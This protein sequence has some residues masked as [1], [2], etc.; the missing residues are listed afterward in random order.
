MSWP[1]PSDLESLVARFHART[2]PKSEWTHLAHLAVGTWQVHAEGPERALATLR[3][4]IQL[5]N[6]A[7]GTANTDTGGYHET[8][9][10]AY[11]VLIAESLRQPARQADLA[12][13]VQELLA[14]PLAPREAL[15]AFYSKA[16]LF[17]VEARRGWVEP[18]R[19]PLTLER[20]LGDTAHVAQG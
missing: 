15:L 6:E 14:S 13:S 11:V 17:S 9:T 1:S 2:L 19:A 12:A 5:L 18:D 8:I 20:L 4:G 10:T 7:H 3:T 16:R